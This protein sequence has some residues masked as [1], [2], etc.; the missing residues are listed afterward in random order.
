SISAWIRFAVVNS[1]STTL[2][3]ADSTHPN[4]HRAGAAA[5]SPEA[6]S[7]PAQDTRQRRAILRERRDHD[8][9]P[10]SDFLALDEVGLIKDVIAH[11][12]NLTYHTTDL[13]GVVEVH[14][15]ISS[16]QRSTVKLARLKFPAH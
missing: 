10:L 13:S 9:E 12:L 5:L 11:Q 3:K 6:D 7:I 14:E 2:D 16:V 15:T 4:R 8:E 1:C